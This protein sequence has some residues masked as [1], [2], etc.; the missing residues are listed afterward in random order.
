MQ[1]GNVIVNRCINFNIFTLN[2]TVQLS[3]GQWYKHFSLSGIL[4]FT[5]AGGSC[6]FFFFQ[7]FSLASIKLCTKGLIFP[8]SPRQR[9]ILLATS[10]AVNKNNTKFFFVV[11]NIQFLCNAMVSYNW[12]SYNYFTDV[13]SFT[14]NQS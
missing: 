12:I 13:I 6:F 4:V 11:A 10:T 5:S 3:V 8:F 14:N 7:L 9:K 1:N 2:S